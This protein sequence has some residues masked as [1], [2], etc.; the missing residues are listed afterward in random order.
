MYP[1]AG[2]EVINEQVASTVTTATWLD[3]CY[4]G[5]LISSEFYC[6]GNCNSRAEA[7]GVLQNKSSSHSCISSVM[8]E[9]N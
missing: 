7:S 6:S 8:H 9:A 1:E 3:Q 5:F 2:P 4:G